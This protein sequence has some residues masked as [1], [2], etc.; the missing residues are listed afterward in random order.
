MYWSGNTF[1]SSVNN[2]V[3]KWHIQVNFHS[4]SDS[5]L[6]VF[7]YLIFFQLVV[8]DDNET[9]FIQTR[10][11][12]PVFWEQPGVQVSSNCSKLSKF[13]NRTETIFKHQLIS[14]SILT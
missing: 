9:S 2:A 3:D 6:C 11:S 4:F 8:L 10:G 7:I 5:N 1:T 14:L 12:V 13:K